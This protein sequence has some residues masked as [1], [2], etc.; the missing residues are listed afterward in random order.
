VK[1]IVDALCHIRP[2]ADN[3]PH[4]I[5]NGLLLRSDL[6]NLF[7]LGYLTVT[8]DYRVKV[9]RRIREEFENGHDYYALDKQPLQVMPRLESARPAREFLEWHHRV[10]KG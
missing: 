9:S 10:F 2:F 7:D 4:Q 3:G 8:L 6:H 5:D 1:P